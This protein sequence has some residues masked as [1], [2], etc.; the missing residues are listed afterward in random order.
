M[1]SC[2]CPYDE[3]AIKS[4]FT[5]VVPAHTRV[6]RVIVM[7]GKSK[8]ARKIKLMKYSISTD[9]PQTDPCLSW[10]EL[11]QEFE[12]SLSGTAQ[13]K[14]V[15]N[16]L[17]NHILNLT[18]ILAASKYAQS[19]EPSPLWQVII[20]LV[21]LHIYRWSTIPNTRSTDGVVYTYPICLDDN[22]FEEI[23]LNHKHPHMLQASSSA[24]LGVVV[25][26]V[27]Q[28]PDERKWD[29]LAVLWMAFIFSTKLAHAKDGI[30]GGLYGFRDYVHATLT[31]LIIREEVTRAMKRKLCAVMLAGAIL[32][33]D[34]NLEKQRNIQRTLT[35][36]SNMV[37]SI[38]TAAPQP[39]SAVSVSILSLIQPVLDHW[40]SKRKK[41]C[42]TIKD[43]V[44]HVC[45][46][47]LGSNV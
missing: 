32:H 12:W 22:C 46:T 18:S 19:R 15:L 2:S 45:S 16:N 35:T 5:K 26:I 20:K 42:D 3:Q 39:T 11:Q 8:K 37:Y 41:D 40:N 30:P 6:R 25:A 14:V 38:T 24:L 10:G 33:V 23:L 43:E 9:H 7:D 36:V 34:Y 13:T 44:T 47:Y 21:L 28:L 31:G 29:S 17:S 4:L 27:Q 1:W